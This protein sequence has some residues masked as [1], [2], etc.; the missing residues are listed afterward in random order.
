MRGYSEVKLKCVDGRTDELD[1][2]IDWYGFDIN[3]S[4]WRPGEGGV[5]YS[6]IRAWEYASINDTDLLVFEDDAKPTSR[7]PQ[8]IK[9]LELPPDYDF[10]SL[11]V[12]YSDH[13]AIMP[14]KLVKSYQEHGMVCMLYSPKGARKM[15]SMLAEE[16]LR[17]PVD[18]WIFKKEIA[19]EL[20]GYAPMQ[21]SHRIVTHDFV[22][23]TNIHIDERIPVHQPVDK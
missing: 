13:N 2:A 15:L 20:I 12:P 22:V 8:V 1:E 10:I 23:P 14:F 21:F 19:G 6:N 7:F 3:F 18:I 4:E 16:G 9:G 17:W 11:Y 5:W